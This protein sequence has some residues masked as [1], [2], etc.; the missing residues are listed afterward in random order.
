M[1]SFL[2]LQDTLESSGF[3]KALSVV[4][5]VSMIYVSVLLHLG[6]P[7]AEVIKWR[8]LSDTLLS[9]AP[10]ESAIYFVLSG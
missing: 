6:L 2:G 8:I 9:A 4:E 10:W 5:F 1:W 7:E 3:W